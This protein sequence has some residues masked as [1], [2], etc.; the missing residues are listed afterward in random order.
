MTKEITFEQSSGNV[1][2]DLDLPNPEALLLQSEIIVEIQRQMLKYGLTSRDLA[3]TANVSHSI[4]EDILCGRRNY[5]LTTIVQFYADLG[6]TISLKFHF[7]DAKLKEKAL[8]APV[9]KNNPDLYE[10]NPAWADTYVV[11]YYDITTVEL[12][13]VKASSIELALKMAKDKFGH[14]RKILHV[15]KQ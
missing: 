9:I 3:R 5:S 13:T 15:Q 11:Y 8:S 10:K 2:K 1:F 4:V 14:I 12:G 6:G 7:S